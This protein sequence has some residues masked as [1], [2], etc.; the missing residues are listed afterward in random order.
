MGKMASQISSLT[1][2]YST[3]YSG[4][5]RR[6]HQSFAS[7]AFVRGIY[8]WPVNSPHKGPVTR[9]MFP[10]FSLRCFERDV[11]KPESGFRD[12]SWNTIGRFGT[13]LTNCFQE[14]LMV[15]HGVFTIYSMTLGPL[16]WHVLTLIPTWISNHILSN[17]WDEITYRFS[18]FNGAT[19][20][21]WEWICNFIPLF[22]MDVITC[23][24]WDWI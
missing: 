24:R 8:Q 6:K 17:V 9:K 18:N 3:V 21:V 7:L 4:A 15:I 20:E 11:T 23:P 2:V 16:Y 13:L 5:D 12:W 22:M 1:I 19:V 14:F 10:F